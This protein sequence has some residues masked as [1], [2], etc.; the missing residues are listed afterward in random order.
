[1]NIPISALFT[2]IFFS[3]IAQKQD[4]W[5]ITKQEGDIKIYM[6]KS[7]ESRFKEVM[8][9]MQVNSNLGALVY[10]VKDTKNHYKWIYA[11][12]NA[13]MLK[14]VNDFEWYYY[15]VSE[16]PWPVSN[17]DVITHAIMWQDKNT[18]K[19]TINSVGAPDY[20]PKKKDLVRIPRILTSWE[21]TPLGKNLVEVRFKLAIDLGGDIPA[22]LV[23]LAVD[24]GPFNTMSNMAKLIQ[25]GT[26]RNVNLSYIKE[27]Y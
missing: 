1:M 22:W 2:L 27:K 11:N 12:K 26:A 14:S 9:T 24:K 13:E 19:V 7:D 6:R 17:R 8:G 23:N 16:A 18:Y 15:N 25:S 3:A 10:L 21:F 5:K 4:D 20:I